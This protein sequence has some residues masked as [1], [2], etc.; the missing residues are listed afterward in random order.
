MVIDLAAVRA[1]R[2]PQ[3][4]PAPPVQRPSGFYLVSPT[5]A[6]RRAFRE[7]TEAAG[8]AYAAAATHRAG[9]DLVGAA[10]LVNA[11]GQALAQAAEIG[12]QI[13]RL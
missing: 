7:L 11:A 4:L 5:E 3:P 8:R 12:E 6:H 10:L 2:H 9:G 1:Q 13:A